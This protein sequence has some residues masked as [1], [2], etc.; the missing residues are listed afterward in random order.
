MLLDDVDAFYDYFVICWVDIAH[1]ASLAFV[2]AGYD[3]HCI[4]SFNVHPTLRSG[5]MNFEF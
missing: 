3:Q 5:I 4:I 1:A 2:L